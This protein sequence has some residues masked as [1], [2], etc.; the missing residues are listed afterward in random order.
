MERKNQ[1]ENQNQ[2]WKGWKNLYIQSLKNIEDLKSQIE[3]NQSSKGSLR[4]TQ[5]LEL[6]R[7]NP[8]TIYDIS[9]KLDISN[10][11]V[12]SILCYLKNDEYRIAT[13]SKKEKF[14]EDYDY[15]Q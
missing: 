11:N 1:M 10:K 14:L 4:K 8:I 3:S 12:S 9:M 2:E 13:N 6:L 7:Q 15:S 5:V